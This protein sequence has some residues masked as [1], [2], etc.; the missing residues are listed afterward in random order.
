MANII[1]FEIDKTRGGALTLT[2]CIDGTPLTDLISNF[3]VS[4]GFIDPAGGY[5]GLVPSYF[6][7]G[8]LEQYF[9]GQ[10]SNRG[11]SDKVGEI[12]VLGCQCGEVGCWPLRTSV[13]RVDGS[14]QWSGFNQ[15][16]RPMRNY[17]AFGPFVFEKAQYEAAVRDVALK[18]EQ[19]R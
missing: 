10:T 5:G 16:H 3:E 1:S 19:A 4:S 17:D 9:R 11:I 8:P 6:R 18:C 7:Y 2:P 12:F 15:P 14:Y 13:T